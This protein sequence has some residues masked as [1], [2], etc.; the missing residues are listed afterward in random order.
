MNMNL[1]Q[2]TNADSYQ[3]V[4]DIQYRSDKFIALG[5]LLQAEVIHVVIQHVTRSAAHPRVTVSYKMIHRIRHL[6]LTHRRSE[7]SLPK[8]VQL[9][10]G[11]RVTAI[12]T[13][14]RLHH[15]CDR[16]RSELSG[17]IGEIAA[18]R[19]PIIVTPTPIR[20]ISISHIPVRWLLFLPHCTVLSM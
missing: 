8:S 1:S 5:S 4:V 13:V 16:R 6:L 18:D 12:G 3:T 7:G 11:W 9:H 19:T 20:N 2:P 10:D 15:A 14:L 17:D